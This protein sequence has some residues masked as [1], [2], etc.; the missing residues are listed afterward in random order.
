MS[1][2]R[3]DDRDVEHAVS[4]LQAMPGMQDSVCPQIGVILGSGLGSAAD[5]LLSGGGKAV[6]YQNIPGMPV[7]HV[8]GHS[9][10]LV[11]GAIHGRSVV[12]LQG[13]VHFYE[14][15]TV[16][17][18]T[19]GV[20]L[21]R[22]LGIQQLIITNAAGGIRDGIL[23][24]DLMLISDHIRPLAVAELRFDTM[25][26]NASLVGDTGRPLL[27]SNTLRDA[28]KSVRT[29]L[30]IH[31]G[32]YSMMTGPAYE[33]AAEIRMLRWLGADAVGMST[34]PEA[35]CAASLGIEVLGVSCI[36]NVAAGLSTQLLS[37]HEVTTAAASIAAPFADWL[38]DVIAVMATARP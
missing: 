16:E 37:H 4:V 18:V 29:Q 14:G 33:T 19:F 9:G 38:W 6:S 26:A 2:T 10:R 27:W 35:L 34:V 24:G 28:A 30:R 7:P 11:F 13:R 12:M 31:Q 22:R 5:R 36:T 21:M 20:R 1:A 15:G 23:P 32:V 25:M 3:S 17:S 8:A